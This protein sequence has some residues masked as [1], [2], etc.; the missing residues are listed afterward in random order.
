M[1]HQ[2]F[3]RMEEVTWRGISPTS[4]SSLDWNSVVAFT[5]TGIKSSGDR[6]ALAGIRL[7]RVE[8]VALR[9]RRLE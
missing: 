7:G 4:A 1:H 5:M 6:F 9:G 2:F 8:P 3:V